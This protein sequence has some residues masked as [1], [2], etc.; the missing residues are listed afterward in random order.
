MKTIQAV[1]YPV[2]F[3]KDSYQELSKLIEIKNYSTIFILVDENTFE[4]CYPKFIQNLSIDKIGISYRL[5]FDL[6]V[7]NSLKKL[8]Q[9]SVETIGMF[10]SIYNM[11]IIIMIVNCYN[12]RF[13]IDEL[14][15]CHILPGAHKAKLL[16]HFLN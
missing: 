2:H 16:S 12:D 9:T 4:Y 6:W 1:T 14:V 13:F 3:H 11:K 7:E 8:V 5:K 15:L 10:Y